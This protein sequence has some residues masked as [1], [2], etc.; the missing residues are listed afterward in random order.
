MSDAAG[1]EQQ[2][3][4][5]D[6]T[7]LVGDLLQRCRDLLDELGEFKT[8][9]VEQ[10]KDNAVELRQFYNSVASELKSLEKVSGFLTMAVPRVLIE[11]PALQRRSDRRPHNPYSP[12]LQSAI[13]YCGVDGRKIMYRLSDL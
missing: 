1:G 11:H 2:P 5:A 9:L 13:L 12:L 10:K 3:S 6:N 7:V 8:F 4:S